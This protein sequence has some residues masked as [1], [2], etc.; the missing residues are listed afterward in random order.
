M[1]VYIILGI[2]FFIL[3]ILI[4]LLIIN[5]G[6]LKSVVLK[7]NEA[8]D[9]IDKILIEK[10]TT[11]SKI[12]KS[13]KNKSDVDY[14]KGLYDTNIEELNSIELNKLLSKYDNAITELADYNKDL[15]YNDDDLCDFEKLNSI[16]INRLATEKYYND[17]VVIYNKLI[18]K[19]PLNILSKLKGYDEKDLFTNEKEEVFEILKN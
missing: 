19:F 5:S 16:N 4:L 10:Y 2:I 11:M 1:M 13:L 7:I 3:F 8:E 12:D 6:N 17:N 14:F 9:N 18:K 15:N